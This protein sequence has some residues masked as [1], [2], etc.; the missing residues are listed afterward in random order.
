MMMVRNT[1]SLKGFCS[2]LMSAWMVVGL[3]GCS[4]VRTESVADFAVAEQTDTVRGHGENNGEE[5]AAFTVDAPVSGPQA[6]VDS[7][8]TFLNNELYEACEACAHFD[9]QTVS[10][11]KEEMFTGN[12]EQLLSHYME[13]YRP[14]IADSL[15]KTF[16][17]RL[18]KESQT[19]KYVTYGVEVFHCSLACSSQKAYYTFDMHDGHQVKEVIS[20]D[21]LIRFFED[22]PEYNSIGADAWA[23]SPGWKF[24]PENRFDN[25]C[26]GLLDSCFMLAIPGYGNHFLL[27]DFPYG[28]VFSYLTPEAQ[29]LVEQTGEGEPM[30][31]P[32][33]PER[34]EDGEVWMEVDTVHCA[35]LG[36]I[37]AAGGPLVDTLMHYEPELEVYPKRVHSIN[38]AEGATIFLFIYS[39]GHLMYC[40]EAM[41][42]ALGE[43]GLQPATL[44]SLESQKDSVISCMWYDQLVEASN[45]FPFDEVDENRFGIHYDPFTKRLYVPIMDEHDKGSEYA[46]TSCLQYTGRYH[47]LQFDGKVFVPAGDDGA[48]W[49]NADLRNYKRTVSNRK[50]AAGIEQVDLMPDGT[51]RR[52]VWKG[53]K[54]L[55]DLR[56]KPDEVVDKK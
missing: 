22:Y 41:T 2:C 36:Y 43:D 31:P 45:G 32:Y 23:G 4:S 46:N 29:K 50:T 1:L 14:L 37:S 10:F 38:A 26:C 55:D 35:L 20:H 44:F 42:V 17:V 27:V 49:L 54:T 56:K 33:L 15:W 18:I 52:A 39:R 5:W 40:D 30:L 53:A 13:K 8:L 25:T 16:G 7:V 28:Q 51:T 48:W 24:S 6:L 12:G 47:V 19:A 3:F 11:K 9:E 21:N 34:S